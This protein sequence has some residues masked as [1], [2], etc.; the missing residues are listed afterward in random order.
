MENLNLA[1]NYTSPWIWVTDVGIFLGDRIRLTS[2]NLAEKGTLSH[3]RTSRGD[4]PFPEGHRGV[5][6]SRTALK[7]ADLG[8]QL[9]VE[10]AQ[11]QAKVA[12]LEAKQQ[13]AERIRREYEGKTVWQKIWAWIY[14]L[15]TCGSDD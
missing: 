4:R 7:P 14:W 2:R 12:K 11:T 6:G 8:A 15:V 1:D 3:K 13:E 9:E 5:S 10:R